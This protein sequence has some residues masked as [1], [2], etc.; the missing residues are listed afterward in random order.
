MITPHEHFMQRCFELAAKGRSHVHHNPM[1]GAVIVHD[2]K[3]IGEGYHQKYGEA[4]AE[5][6]ALASV[7]PEDRNLLKHSTIYVNL[8]PCN[9]RGKTG[10]CT[11]APVFPR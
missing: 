8:E 5:I 1:V 7:S 3:I 11:K 2:N 9:H 6:N 10:A 4:H